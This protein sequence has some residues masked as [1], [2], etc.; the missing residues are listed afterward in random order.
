[1]AVSA[2]ACDPRRIRKLP[3]AAFAVASL[4]IVVEAEDL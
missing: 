2:G 4:G 1:M 3:F